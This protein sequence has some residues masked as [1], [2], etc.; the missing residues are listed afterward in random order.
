MPVVRDHPNWWICMTY[1]GFKPQVNVDE[2]LKVFYNHRIRVVKEEDGTLHE[3]QAY[4]QD[5]TK[6]DKRVS[7]QLLEMCRTRVSSHID[8]WKL[9][10]ILTV[11]IKNLLS[12]VWQKYF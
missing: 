11:G 1:D 10:A 7:C 6:Q 5:Q 3:N 2:A 12:S 4:D 9:I 8:Q